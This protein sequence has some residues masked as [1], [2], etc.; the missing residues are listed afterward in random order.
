MTSHCVIKFIDE[1]LGRI[2][3]T[4]N[5]R[6]L[7][8]KKFLPSSAKDLPDGHVKVKWQK[9]TSGSF[10]SDGYFEAEVLAIAGKLNL[11][12]LNCIPETLKKFSL[13]P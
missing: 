4:V 13:F 3:P 8:K 2:T 1:F 7:D 12:L 11:F 5:I 10:S 9:S 6:T